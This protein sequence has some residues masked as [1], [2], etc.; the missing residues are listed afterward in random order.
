MAKLKNGGREHLSAPVSFSV[1]VPRSA[2]KTTVDDW[3]NR[4]RRPTISDEH[5]EGFVRG[6]IDVVTT[7]TVG[8]DFTYDPIW[9]QRRQW[10]RL[11]HRI[12]QGAKG[13]VL[14]VGEGSVF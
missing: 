3:T 7:K 5:R 13:E 6:V 4:L 1:K 9:S 2:Q 11:V 14:N 12:T 8:S 10:G